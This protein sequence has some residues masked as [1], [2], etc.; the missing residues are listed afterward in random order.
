M[1]RRWLRRIFGDRR[2]LYGPPVGPW[3]TEVALR[4][5]YAERVRAALNAPSPMLDD[6]KHVALHNK[7]L[8]SN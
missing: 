4:H 7:Y 3:Y 6:L 8:R 5:Y 1:F 2:P